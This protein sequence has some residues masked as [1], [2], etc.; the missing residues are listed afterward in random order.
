MSNGTS[1]ETK[2]LSALELTNAISNRTLTPDQLITTF[3]HYSEYDIQGQ[4]PIYR[5][6]GGIKTALTNIGRQLTPHQ[7]EQLL[8][9]DEL[10]R[11]RGLYPR[12]PYHE[13]DIGFTL[14][15]FAKEQGFE[16]GDIQLRPINR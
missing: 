8:V 16:I 3:T 7:L 11:A 4:P 15:Y 5:Y 9:T 1:P 2:P 6:F 12:P 14:R 13:Y 10:I